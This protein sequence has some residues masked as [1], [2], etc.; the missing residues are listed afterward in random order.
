MLCGPKILCA[1]RLSAAIGLQGL[2]LYIFELEAGFFVGDSGHL[3]GRV[4]ASKDFLFTQKAIAQLRLEA[5]AA[6][7][8]SPEFETGSGVNDL[9]LGLR[10][11]YEFKREIAPYVGVTWTNLY[12][13]T[14]E[15]R[16]SAGGESSNWKAIGGLRIWF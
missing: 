6:A 11:R 9:S 2:A 3:A 1:S 15:L 5:N 13:E 10:L 12:G 7:K 16:K 14:S 8:R 4:T